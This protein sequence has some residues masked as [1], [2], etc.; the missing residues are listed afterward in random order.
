MLAPAQQSFRR[1]LLSL[2]R[3]HASLVA[4][5][6]PGTDHTAVPPRPRA[7]QPNQIQTNSTAG[8]AVPAGQYSD[9]FH[10]RTR[11]IAHALAEGR[12]IP[13]NLL[14]KIL[15]NRNIPPDA[16]AL[17]V[18][19]LARRDPI[20]ALERLGL[21]ESAGIE[22][23]GSNQHR[24]GAKD[25]PDWLYLALPGL[26]TD[27][28]QVPYLASQILSDRFARLD[29]QNRAV[30]VARCIQ[31]SLRVRHYVALRE[32]VEW[33]AYASPDVDSTALT[34]AKS[35]E[36]VLAA[37]ASER[38]RSDRYDAT[39]PL[40][41]EPLVDLVLSAYARRTGQ[42]R[43]TKSMYRTLFSP[44]LVPREPE[45]ALRLVA[46]MTR[47]GVTPS[48]AM[49]QQV[50]RVCARSG[51]HGAALRILEQIRGEVSP[52]DARHGGGD[53]R[54]LVPVGEWAVRLDEAIEQAHASA[55]ET[56]V[57]L[58]LRGWSSADLDRELESYPVRAPA[59]S[60]VPDGDQWPSE[61]D[62]RVRAAPAPPESTA[63]SGTD[64]CV[65]LSGLKAFP[66]RRQDVFSTVLLTDRANVLPYFHELLFYATSPSTSASGSFPSPPF[67]FDRV[68][69]IQFFQ[70]VS[71]QPDV[72]A[73][74]LVAV[75]QAVARASTA[76]STSTA[77][78]PPPPTLRLHTIVMQ[79][80]VRRDEP[81]A[82]LHM[83]RFLERRGWQPDATL[84]DVV[85]RAHLAL[86]HDRPALRILEHYA[87]RPGIDA[88]EALVPLPPSR[89]GPDVTT[90]ARP[91][92]VALTPVPLNALLAYYS[93]R[94]RF[95]A[96]H[97][98]WTEFESR[99]G[100]KPD[101][102]TLSIMLD[103]ARHASS[104]AG[105][106]W[107]PMS[108][109]EEVSAAGPVFGGAM[110]AH[111]TTGGGWPSSSHHDPD[112]GSR[113]VD[114]S[115]DGEPASRF[116]ERFVT[117][118]VLELN[119]QNFELE[120]PWE[121]RGV[122]VDWLARRFARSGGEAPRRRDSGQ[123]TPYSRAAWS[124]VCPPDWRPF[125]TTLSP[126]PPTRP[127][128]YP[129]DRVFRS[130]I[131]LVGTHSSNTV[132]PTLVSWMRHVHVRPSRFTL[133]VAL[134]YVDGEASFRPEQM[135]RWRIW[136][137]DWL[138]E[139]AIPTEA[140]IAWM[141]RGGKREGRPVTRRI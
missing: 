6:Q 128:L 108:A 52:L 33:V 83:W 32:L 100:A 59:P 17:W 69:W 73:D 22:M 46:R 44:K 35:F 61:G 98:L 131:R 38:V 49:L 76:P 114:D 110:A 63:T 84:L 103:A 51:R 75:L 89:V 129:T 96:V 99:F 21:L 40:V 48:R 121:T 23:P 91:R 3:H 10:A 124:Q 120:T 116:M 86:D 37:L 65:D 80:L 78:V 36:T 66:E 140:E 16:L 141:R 102:A 1:P 132:I 106:G 25:C 97:S 133:C 39:P 43:L 67:H 27:A 13:R 18:D 95:G 127:H 88:P 47:E 20:Y 54:E 7:A 117:H 14:L 139:E 101:S 26:V 28:A 87:H 70:T 56:E 8:S 107:T 109:F 29:E 71:L 119:W 19:V 60:A 104:R 5:C 50:M 2:V 135:D 93:Q 134:A 74:H 58:H 105:R 15:A 85:V 136:L 34:E 122:V 79:A 12:H 45:P 57:P 138:G 72:T 126:T 77:Y 115:W 123:A 92:S 130:L 82:A 11:S 118:E 94:N 31:H 9:Y 111:R 137:A 125:A 41:L 55:A 53:A 64:P 62:V 42:S 24:I 4:P 113:P 68:S 112:H 81:R 90:A 30:F